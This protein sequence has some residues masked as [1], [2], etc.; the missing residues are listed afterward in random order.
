MQEQLE[1]VLSYARGVWKR[2]WWV[3][4]IAWLVAVVGWVFVQRLPDEYESSARVYVDTQ[5]LLKPLL[6][7]L[8]IQMDVGQEIRLMERTLLSRPN[9]EKIVRMTDLDL[10]AT[11]DVEYEALLNR[12]KGNIEMSKD[13]RQ[14]L[15]SISYSDSDPE[16]AKRVVQA[17]VT[18]FIENTIGERRDSTATASAQRFLDKQISEY[19]QRLRESEARLKEFKQN[20]VAFMSGSGGYFQQL[21][22]AQTQLETAR[23]ELKEAEERR[24]SILWQ[25][26]NEESED[27]LMPD[28]GLGSGASVATPYDGRIENL[29]TQLDSMLLR[30]TEQHPSVIELRRTL[31]ELEKLRDEEVARATSADLSPNAD[32]RGPFYQQLRLALSQAEATVASLTAR[33][34]NFQ[35]KA[36]ALQAKVDTVPEIEAQLTALNR[37]YGIT[38]T[39]YEELLNRRESALMSQRVEEDVNDIQFRVIDPP[40]VSATPT[41]PN[42]PLLMAG[43]LGVGLVI[44]GGLATLFSLLRPTFTS[45][46][47]L[48]QITG[49][50]VLGTVSYQVATGEARRQHRLMLAFWG[51]TLMLLAAYCALV[52]YNLFL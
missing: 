16:Q 33:V 29:N 5:S 45:T 50:Q 28:F 21:Q 6:R 44:G 11:T 7:G 40:R 48:G 32:D 22:N 47:L 49:V 17:V 46:L 51:G 25:L 12:L 36:E 4:A 8:T 34:A 31:A 41:G 3:L 30:Y 37:D 18:T 52:A 35:S 43:V 39:K 38:K 19:E 42:R 10:A 13:S 27:L 1:L 14:N 9:L 24:D 20:N 23:L 26:E 2:R 15:Y